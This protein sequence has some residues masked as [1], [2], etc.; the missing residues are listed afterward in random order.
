MQAEFTR[1]L[2][3]ADSCGLPLREQGGDRAAWS[4]GSPLPHRCFVLGEFLEQFERL[5]VARP[6]HAISFPVVECFFSTSHAHVAGMLRSRPHVARLEQFHC[7]SAVGAQG[8]LKS[9]LGVFHFAELHQRDG[10]RVGDVWPDVIW[11]ASIQR[12]CL[13]PIARVEEGLH[14]QVPCSQVVIGIH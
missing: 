7:H 8:S 3:S 10:S 14:E 1:R 13:G 5:A 11:I 4:S 9:H 12:C 2:R 6:M